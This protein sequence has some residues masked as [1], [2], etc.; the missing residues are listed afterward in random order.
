[1]KRG[2]LY[3]APQ[4]CH[5]VVSSGGTLALDDGPR[6]NFVRPAGNPL[7]ASAASVFGPRVVGVV[8][9]GCDGD[10]AAGLRAIKRAGG[11][12]IVQHPGQAE[13][14]DMPMHALNH[15][16]P[17]YPS[18]C[19]N[20][21]PCSMPWP[22]VVTPTH[23]ERE[24]GRT[25]LEGASPAAVRYY[26]SAKQGR[27]PDGSGAIPHSLFVGHGEFPRGTL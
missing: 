6:V 13:A 5:L 4:K 2:H 1:M 24:A 7:F 26:R 12:S 15:V 11:I 20:W 3:L 8:L 9:T 18:R 10:G 16:S 21:V 23:I 19:P 27:G 17:D 25:P 14:P 22:K